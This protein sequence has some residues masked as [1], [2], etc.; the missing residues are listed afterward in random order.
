MSSTAEAEAATPGVG[1]QLQQGWH[2]LAGHFGEIQTLL[3]VCVVYLFVIG[4]TALITTLSRRDLLAKRGF[5]GSASAWQ[6][7]DSTA[8]PDLQ[9]AKRQF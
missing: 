1:R 9:R 4:P 3:I 2:E 6:T 5:D 7:A 8:C